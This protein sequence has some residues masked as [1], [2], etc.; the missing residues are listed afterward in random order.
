MNSGKGR[1]LAA[2]AVAVCTFATS[3]TTVNASDPGIRD[4][5]GT[6]KRA[7][8]RSVEWAES[9]KCYIVGVSRSNPKWALAGPSSKCGPNSGHSAV[10][11]QKRSGQWKFLFYDMDN[12]GCDRFRMPASVRADFRYYVC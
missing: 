11:K 2:V 3:T 10:F 12:N 8:L 9:P 5:R 7:F 1:G 4:L 6:E